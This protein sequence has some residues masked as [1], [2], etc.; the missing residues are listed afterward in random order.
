ME[1]SE[2]YYNQV[3]MV[4][5]INKQKQKKSL[6]GKRTIFKAFFGESQ[7]MVTL[8]KNNKKKTNKQ[9][10]I[11]YWYLIFKRRYRHFMDN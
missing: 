1:L 7:L 3:A 8:R 6:P 10:N 9:T 11:N 4:Y 5:M 2:M